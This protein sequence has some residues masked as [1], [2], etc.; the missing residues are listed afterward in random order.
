MWRRGRCPFRNTAWRGRRR[1]QVKTGVGFGDASFPRN[2]GHSSDGRVK[3]VVE[4]LGVMSKLERCQIYLRVSYS[5]WQG[6]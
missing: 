6:Y 3:R 2:V 4:Q 1:F 5:Y